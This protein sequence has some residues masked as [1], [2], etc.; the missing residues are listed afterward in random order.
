[1]AEIKNKNAN[2]TQVILVV[3]YF[4]M[5]PL[6]PCIALQ[7]HNVYALT[8]TDRYNRGFLH[9]G[10]QAR[11]DFQNGNSFNRTC[12]SGH[13]SSYCDGWL[14]GYTTTWNNIAQEPPPNPNPPSSNTNTIASNPPVSNT[15][16]PRQIST[17]KTHLM[18]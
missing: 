3:L 16:T 17:T 9:G 13:T 15:T 5:V 7:K 18:T 12:P 2:V 10:Q 1:M 6:T 4:S 11:T 8:S 14:N